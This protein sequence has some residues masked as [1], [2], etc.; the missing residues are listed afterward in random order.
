MSGGP[1]PPFPGSPPRP[2]CR[3]SRRGLRPVGDGPL[4]HGTTCAAACCTSWAPWC[5]TGWG[6]GAAGRGRCTARQAGFYQRTGGQ[7]GAPP[8][9]RWLCS[10][11]RNPN[12]CSK[13]KCIKIKS[14]CALSVD[15]VLWHI[16]K[17]SSMN[18]NLVSPNLILLFFVAPACSIVRSNL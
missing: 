12:E 7:T 4:P 15:L 14:M 17:L 1:S 10:Y 9:W 6:T 16:D 18:N 3:L 11:S 5:A 8:G 2:G 13:R